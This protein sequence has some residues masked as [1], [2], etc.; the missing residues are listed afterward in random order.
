[1]M[2]LTV[3]QHLMRNALKKKKKMQEKFDDKLLIKTLFNIDDI[4]FLVGQTT[5]VV[6]LHINSF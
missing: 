1:M 2:L 4:W 6:Y 3:I 5:T